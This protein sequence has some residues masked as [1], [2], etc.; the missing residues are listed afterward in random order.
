MKLYIYEHCPF[1]ARAR[2]IF[3]LKKVPVEL[4]VLLSD[5]FKTPERMIG[6]K[7]VPILQKDDGSYLLESLDIVDYIDHNYGGKP[8]LTGVRS[9]EIAELIKQF[10]QYD[11]RLECPRYIKMGFAE[12]ATQSAINDFVASKS[13][14]MGAFADCMAQTDTLVSAVSN[15]LDRL[16]PF[17]ISPDACN[18]SLSLD[19]ICLFPVLRNLTCVKELNFPDK[20]RSY[21]QSMS[22]LSQVDLFFE[23]AI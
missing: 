12:F 16:E 21:L 11:Y 23:R 9:P 2:M 4:H 1:C 6:E 15:I 13:N 7:M 18:G 3:G 20:I 19:D 8:I 5:D 14:K 10:Q 22:K 17:I